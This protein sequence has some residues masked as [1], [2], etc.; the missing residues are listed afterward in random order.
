VTVIKEI[1]RLL[2][3]HRETLERAH[4]PMI[5]QSIAIEHYVS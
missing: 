1:A 4:R 3:E 5:A 2:L